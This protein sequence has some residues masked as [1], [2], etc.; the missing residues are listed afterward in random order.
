V[1]LQLILLLVLTQNFG[2][3][4]VSDAVEPEQATVC[5]ILENLR[6]YDGKVVAIQ[7]VNWPVRGT[8]CQAPTTADDP[9][10]FKPGEPPVNEIDVVP[11]IALQLERKALHKYYRWYRQGYDVRMKIVGRIEVRPAGNSPG[12]GH[13]GTTP[14]QISVTRIEDMKRSAKKGPKRGFT[15]GVDAVEAVQP[16]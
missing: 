5:Q 1:V 9:R 8:Q 12:Y 4:K 14:A 15:Y 10:L 7:V 16:F 3:R 11:S 6:W 13:F 2:D